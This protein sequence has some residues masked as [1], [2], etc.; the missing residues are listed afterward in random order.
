MFGIST[1]IADHSLT[2]SGHL[3]NLS[4]FETWNSDASD[5][6][7][8]SVGKTRKDLDRHSDIAKKV[9]DAARKAEQEVQEV[10]NALRKLRAD[11]AAAGF[12]L[13]PHT[14]VISD[15]HP[16][17][18]ECMT[19]EAAQ[20]YVATLERLN[21]ELASV[22]TAAA[23]ADHDLATAIKN[24]DGEWNIVQWKPSAADVLM[25]S[26]GSISGTKSDIIQE[27]WR[28]SMGEHPTGV[29]AKIAPWLEEVGQ[30]KVSRVGGAVGVLTAIPAVF[31]DRAEGNSWGEAITR[32]GAAT[33]TGLVA[34]AYAG[35]QAG[36]VMG[37]FVPIPGVGTVA[38]LVVGAGAGLL[39]SYAT[40]KGVDC[41][42]R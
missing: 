2:T 22:L 13:D 38:G 9:G 4:V 14:D 33:A 12:V 35:A 37:T 17:R 29:N 5:A 3:G 23:C 39:V 42:W 11:I 26:A 8:E 36:A 31:A 30:L 40:S 27:I 24:A 25:G 10:K 32:E 7:R 6:A 15:P 34:G 16:E 18:T 19:D 21:F 20:E 41:L 28:A 1:N